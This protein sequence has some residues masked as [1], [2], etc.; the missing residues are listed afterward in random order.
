MINSKFN[1]GDEVFV[2]ATVREIHVDEN[3]IAYALDIRETG[4][5]APAR[6]LND[7]APYGRY[8]SEDADIL[9][10]VTARVKE[11]D[12]FQSPSEVGDCEIDTQAK[13]AR[14]NYFGDNMELYHDQDDLK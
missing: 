9:Y 4:C 14:L 3:G 6:K 2:K 1:V 8:R 12:I 5:I 7:R 13:P 10:S 11:E